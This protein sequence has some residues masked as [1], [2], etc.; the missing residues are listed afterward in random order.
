MMTVFFFKSEM[1]DGVFVVEMLSKMDVERRSGAE[2]GCLFIQGLGRSEWRGNM[3]ITEPHPHH[4]S[5]L[6]FQ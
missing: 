6:L 3:D 5:S 4:P 2:A 1:G